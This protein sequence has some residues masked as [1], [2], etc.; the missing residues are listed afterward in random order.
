[1]TQDTG[2]SSEL[3][4][5]HRAA[6]GMSENSDAVV[7]VVSEETGN[8]S[9]AINGHLT[10]NYTKDTLTAALKKELIVAEQESDKKLGISSLKIPHITIKKKEK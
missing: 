8:M 1:M 5:R 6:L 3:G 7:V 4:T 9:L 10:R 2:V